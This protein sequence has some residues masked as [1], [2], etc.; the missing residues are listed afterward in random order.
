MQN[1]FNF[2]CFLLVVSFHIFYCIILSLVQDNIVKNSEN[3]IKG[4]FFY[5]YSQNKVYGSI[6]RLKHALSLDKYRVNEHFNLFNANFGL[7]RGSPS[8][9]LRNPKHIDF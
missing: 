6:C 4:A 5:E 3:L 8:R 7:L 9:I 2:T 1:I